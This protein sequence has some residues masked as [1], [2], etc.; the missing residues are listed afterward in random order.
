[1]ASYPNDRSTIVITLH[2]LNDSRSQRVLWL[3]EELGL[4]YELVA[5]QR[6][7]VSNF[8]PP[9]LKKI[10][11]LGKSPVV[12]DGK[13]VLAESAAIVDYLARKYGN[14]KLAPESDVDS[15]DYI[16][17][18]HWMHFAEGSGM[19][20]LLLKLYVSRLGDAGK[21]LWPRIDAELHNHFAYMSGALGG[22]DWFV[23]DRFSAADIQIS[24]V[25][26]AGAMRGPIAEYPNLVRFKE[27]F[28][29]RPAYQRAL[30]RGGPYKF[31]T[32]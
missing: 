20:P 28:R 27:R 6:D 19:L 7:P 12:V 9:E 4:D 25:I 11:P 1:M 3:L 5:Y 24:F 13:R 29:A 10:H 23:A 18:M 32:A 26:E 14:G 31:A 17:Y 8:A 30:E 2:H 22:R 21:P 16:D 15:Q